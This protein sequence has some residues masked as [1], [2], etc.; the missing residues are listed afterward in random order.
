MRVMLMRIDTRY[1]VLLLCP[2]PFCVC[3]YK[4]RV[5]FLDELSFALDVWILNQHLHHRNCLPMV[6][7][8]LSHTLT[9]TNDCVAHA[10]GT[11][12]HVTFFARAAHHVGSSRICMKRLLTLTLLLSISQGRG[13]NLVRF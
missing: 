12:G 1:L 10:C 13:K 6:D 8:R 3:E 2:P 11:T 7:R 4:L 9:D 5:S